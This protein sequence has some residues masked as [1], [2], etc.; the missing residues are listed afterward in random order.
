MEAVVIIAVLFS[1]V[2]I[3]IK[4][5]CTGRDEYKEIP[6]VDCSPR[7]LG[8]MGEPG[9]TEGRRLKGLM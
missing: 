4:I 6:F 2:V 1:F 9:K 7:G 3:F 5:A 8:G